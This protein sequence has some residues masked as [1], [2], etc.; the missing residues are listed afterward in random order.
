MKRKWWLPLG[1]A[2]LGLIAWIAF[3]VALAMQAERSTLLLLATVGALGLEGAI[4][5]T[6]GVLG[7]SAFQAR[8]E[9]WAQLRIA[10][11]KG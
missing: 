1:A 7:V 9:I 8:R 10:F 11:Q 4:W 2:S 3:G 5:T 6:A